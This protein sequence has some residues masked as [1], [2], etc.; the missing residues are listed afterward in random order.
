MKTA[1]RMIVLCLFCTLTILIS[2]CGG[3]EDIPE[4]AAAVVE[5]SA[6]ITEAE[7][8]QT[9]EDEAG[10]E[11]EVEE[12]DEPVE[13][14]GTPGQEVT[15]TAFDGTELQGI[16]YP[17]GVPG[18][19]LVIMMHWA[20][21]DQSD[22]IEMAYWLQ[23]SGLGGDTENPDGLPWLDPSWFP[24]VDVDKTYA[25]FTFTF[26]QCEGGCQAFLRDEWLID[27]Q[28]A[29]EFA[30]GLEGIDQD[31]I[32]VVGASI[33]ADGAADGCLYLNQQYPGSCKGAF[34]LSAG[35]Y[36]TL[37]YEDVVKQLG[38]DMISAWCLYAISDVESANVCGGFEAENY[39][40][41]EIGEGHGM[42]LVRP[43]VDPNPLQLL[44]DFISQ[45]I[46]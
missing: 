22:Y 19:P 28:S 8:V 13:F 10:A 36:L 20:P 30:Y 4:E 44:L 39:T 1:K 29:V 7:D 33:G 2:A 35:D 12:V 6:A 24:E 38:M 25:V 17:A 15:F 21:G 41:Y 40:P 5:D 46:G 16:Y 32:L 9:A 31:N 11:L 14:Q 26:R 23:N 34:S 27:A 42:M 45:T 43:E 37:K 3:G 18:A